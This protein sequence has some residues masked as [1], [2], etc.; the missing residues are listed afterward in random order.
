MFGQLVNYLQNNTDS[1]LLAIWGHL[2][3]SAGSL[4]VAILIGIPAG[5]FSVR[6][7][8]SQKYIVLLFQIL[9]I[10]PSLAVLLLLIPIMG[11]GVRP[12]M[13]AL[14][15][16]AIPPILVNTVT[17]LEEV[18][19]FLLET[20]LACGMTNRQ[21]WWKIRVPLAMPMMSAGIKTAAIEII[22]SATLAAKIGAGGLGEI[23]FT[24]LGLYRIDLLLVG[25]L[26]V[27]ILS[28][29]SGLLFGLFDRIILRYKYI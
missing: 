18:S 26:T 5:M 11:T 28:V 8:G 9:R 13:T 23:I 10:I 3:I 25:G 21:I 6:I 1:Y 7:K 20:A 4:A 16:L 29:S 17:G 24:G 15:I 12:A 14:I 19:D 27:A 2:G 22:A